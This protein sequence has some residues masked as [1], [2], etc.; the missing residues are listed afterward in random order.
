MKPEGTA[1]HIMVAR[2]A[3]ESVLPA[4]KDSGILRHAPG[5]DMMSDP[6]PLGPTL[7]VQR[8]SR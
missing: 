5:G 4:P 1:G 3:V 2:S 6:A 8:T 7:S